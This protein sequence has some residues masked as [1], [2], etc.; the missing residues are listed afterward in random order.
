M[1]KK[2][3][4]EDCG[5]DIS[6]IIP[7]RHLC[8]TC[9]YKKAYFGGLYWKVI[10]RDNHT[11]QECK[12]EVIKGTRTFNVHHK[13]HNCTDN[14][15]ENLEV[16]CL[17][18]HM[19]KR[20]FKCADCGKVVQATSSRQERCLDC[21]EIHRIF[22]ESKRMIKFYT[23]NPTKK[24]AETSIAYYRNKLKIMEDYKNRSLSK[25]DNKSMQ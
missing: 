7:H 1:E 21:G 8:R 4:C 14:R 19:K 24:G 17:K 15:M 2:Y 11:C 25:M 22:M 20:E 10:E 3:I 18:C 5:K 12:K 13:N 6:Y 16:L 9:S 23:N